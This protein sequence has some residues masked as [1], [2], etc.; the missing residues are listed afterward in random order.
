MQGK[1]G[2]NRAM[3][4]HGGLYSSIELTYSPLSYIEYKKLPYIP[5]KPCYTLFEHKVCGFAAWP[6]QKRSRGKII[7][8]KL[9][10]YSILAVYYSIRNERYMLN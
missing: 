6:K 4:G 9:D 2:Q 3:P 10:S 1:T 7:K 5:Y 8:I